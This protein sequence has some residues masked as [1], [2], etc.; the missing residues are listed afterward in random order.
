M[1]RRVLSSGLRVFLALL[2]ILVIAPATAQQ[3]AAQQATTISISTGSSEVGELLRRGRELEIER[4][5]GKALAHYED[6]MRLF[7]GERNLVLG[8]RLRVCDHP[9]CACALRAI[10]GRKPSLAGG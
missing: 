9:P 2:A 6:A 1:R 8:E 7:P 3:P 5:W 10:A 4:R